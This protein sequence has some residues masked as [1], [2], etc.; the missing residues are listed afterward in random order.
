LIVGFAAGGTTDISARL[1]GQWLSERLAQQFIVENRPGAATN[2]ATEAVV[3]ASPDGHTL[4]TISA[5]NTVNATLYPNLS[6]NF[7]RDIAPVAGITR[8]AFVM[9]VHPSFP[10][11]T[12]LDLISYAKANP[13]KLNVGGSSP[14]TQVAVELF[15]TMTGVN[16]TYVPYRGDAPGLTD[17]LGRQVEM[18]FSGAVA[19]T[20]QIKSGTLHALAVTTTTRSPALPETPTVAEF[21]PGYEASVFNGVGAPRNTPRAIIDKLNEEINAGL[22]DPKLKERLAETGGAVLPGSPTDFGRFIAGEI[23]KWGKVIRTAN[24][25]P[26]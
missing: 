5:T 16:I 2:I 9:A 7:I 25:K 18:Y 8:A 1:I 12:I 14:V 10:A 22:A 26:Q 13:G 24:I 15:K 17:V 20:E 21:V 6:F 11:R 23:D 4:L 19:A 3:R